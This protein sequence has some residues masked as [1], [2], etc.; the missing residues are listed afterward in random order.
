[1]REGSRGRTRDGI[2]SAGARTPAVTP[3]GCAECGLML[4]DPLALAV[5]GRQGA[6]GGRDGVSLGSGM[7]G[8]PVALVCGSSGELCAILWHV[9]N[10]EV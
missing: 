1:M 2:W 6:G 9:D 5:G 4:G 7:L 3:H 10:S 8:A